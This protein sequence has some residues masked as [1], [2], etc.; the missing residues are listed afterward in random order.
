MADAIPVEPAPPASG[1]SDEQIDLPEG[2]HIDQP[3]VRDAQFGDDDKAVA[4][5][6][7]WLIHERGHRRI[8]FIGVTSSFTAG[9][10]RREAFLDAMR[11]ADVPIYPEMFE[12][13]DW[14]SASG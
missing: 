7:T 14:S 3:L 5:A 9:A 1:G 11:R 13:G 12:I 4:E 8:G 2:G 10:R 6:I